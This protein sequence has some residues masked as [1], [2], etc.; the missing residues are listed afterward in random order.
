MGNAAM[1]FV[2]KSLYGHMFSL[3]LGICLEV[4]LLDYISL[5]NLLRNR[6]AGFQSGCTFDNSAI[7]V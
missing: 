3:L 4:E 6:Q 7:R 2:Y 1:T 5:F